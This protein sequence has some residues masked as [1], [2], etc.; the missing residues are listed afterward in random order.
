MHF[1]LRGIF[2]FMH[3]IQI[4]CFLCF[5][6]TFP[7]FFF[8]CLDQEKIHLRFSERYRGLK[9]YMDEIYKLNYE[10]LIGDIPCRFKYRQVK[11]IDFK[12]TTDD[13]LEADDRY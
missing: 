8:F 3:Q 1:I 5:R 6:H 2:L 13:I 11:P 10:D 9:D 12:L 4:F 7:P